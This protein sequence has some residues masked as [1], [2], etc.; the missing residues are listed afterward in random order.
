MTRLR[1]FG[2]VVVI[3][4]LG[5]TAASL[6]AGCVHKAIGWFTPVAVGVVAGFWLAKS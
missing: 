1:M 4:V 5:G 6:T 2:W 3:S